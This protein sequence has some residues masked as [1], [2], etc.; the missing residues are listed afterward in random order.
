MS[1]AQRLG[2]YFHAARFAD[3]PQPVVAKCIEHISYNLIRGLQGHAHE[4]S[5]Q[6]RHIARQLSDD[7]GGSATILGVR[8]R[9]QPIDAAFANATTMRALECDDN[10]FPVGV[11]AGIVTLPPA[12]ALAER[13]HRSGKELIAAVVSG[14]EVIGKLG[15]YGTAAWSAPA[16]RRETILYGPFGGAVACGVLLRLNAGQM[17]ESIRYAAQ[18]AMGVAEGNRWDH[19]YSLV[20]RNG[21]LCAMLAQAGGRVSPTALEGRFGFFETFLGAVP[22]DIGAWR[23]ASPRGVEFLGAR[24]KRLPGT[25]WNV[26]PIELLRD[27]VRAEDLQPQQVVQIDIALSDARRN[28]AIGHSLGP[29]E[30]WRACSSAPFQ[31]AM[32]LLDR[33]ESRHERYSQPDNPELLTI[34]RKM[35]VTLEAGHASDDYTRIEVRTVDGRQLRREGHEFFYPRWDDAAELLAAGR[36]L[37]PEEQLRRAAELLANL[38]E[39]GD[40]SELMECFVP[41]PDIRTRE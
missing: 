39:L 22:K 6:A 16:P 23:L 35:R 24:T 21:L 37:L 3:L 12:L 9:V 38:P 34:V 36:A 11:H 5:A 27:L 28:F 13:H 14:Y 20:A 25:A 19:Y 30:S 40:V 33:G 41:V 32:V 2:S 7:G 18:S 10:L 26:V 4:T 29:Y 17:A 15:N 31:M 8:E 1:L